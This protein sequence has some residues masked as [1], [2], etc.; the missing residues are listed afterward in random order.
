M[1]DFRTREDFHYQT[2]RCNVELSKVIQIGLTVSDSESLGQGGVPFWRFNFQFN[3]GTDSL[4]E[5]MAQALQSEGMNFE[6]MRK[7]G[8]EGT[9]F[10]EWLFSSGLVLNDRLRW[11]GFNCLADFGFLLRLATNAPLPATEDAFMALLRLYF[12]HVCDTRLLV[13]LSPHKAK[14]Q[15]DTEALQNMRRGQ[16]VQ[17]VEH[18]LVLFA[19]A[20]RDMDDALAAN[21]LYGL[22][23]SA[24]LLLTNN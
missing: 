23:D 5:E 17:H 13:Q 11:V 6:F 22:T 16:V 24:R 7:S 3:S 20:H 1:G 9:T 12:P 10:G 15:A 14:L 21:A 19:R 8:I 2:T 4:P 18:T